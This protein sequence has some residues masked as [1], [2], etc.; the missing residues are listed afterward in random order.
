[1]IKAHL[2]F[3]LILFFILTAPF[4]LRNCHKSFADFRQGA[5]SNPTHI[6]QGTKPIQ[7]LY[8]GSNEIWTNTNPPTINAF[9]VAPNTIDL[10]TRAT[11]TITFSLAVTG[12]AGQVTNAQIV[13]LPSG[14]NVGTAFVAGAG[15]SISTTLPN[16]AQPQKTTT[17][18]LVA[19][20]SGGSS[21]RDA[22]VTVTKNPTLANCRRTGYIDSTSVYYFGFDVTGLPQPVVTYR[23]SGG[24]QGTVYSGHFSQGSNPYTWSVSGTDWRIQFANANAQSLTLTATNGSGTA[25]CTISNIND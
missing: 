8:L 17:Y 23:F 9:S 13:R 14:A 7:K 16:I 3:L 20:N 11:G 2:H 25:T 22:T 24:Q 18:R 4:T 19:R 12:T 5:G 1:M 10:D 15:S 21:S 6:Y